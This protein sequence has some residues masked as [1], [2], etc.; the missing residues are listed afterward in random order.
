[1]KVKLRYEDVNILDILQYKQNNGCKHVPS[2]WS[3]QNFINNAGSN[4][5]NNQQ[6]LGRRWPH[7]LS[8]TLRTMHIREWL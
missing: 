8:H 7:H 6:T 4:N 3:H 1:M 5:L 2:I